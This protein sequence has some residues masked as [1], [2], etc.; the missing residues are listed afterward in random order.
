M[1]ERTAALSPA[2]PR[3]V[4]DVP[5]HAGEHPWLW[6]CELVLCPDP[7]QVIVWILEPS[8]GDGDLERPEGVHHHRYLVGPLLTQAGLRAAWMWAM[9]DS[10]RVVGDGSELDALPAHE[11]A[12]RVIEHLVGVHVAV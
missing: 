5:E 10:I 9:R 8:R 6:R 1:A 12:R 7:A 2:R 11:L 3:P 4:T